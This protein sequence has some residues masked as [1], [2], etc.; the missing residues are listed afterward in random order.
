MKHKLKLKL[1]SDN[2]PYPASEK[3]FDN[4]TGT[5]FSVISSQL[6][7]K[8]MTIPSNVIILFKSNN[9]EFELYKLRKPQNLPHAER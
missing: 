3:W 1:K 8:C 5:F 7:G 6:G 9:R 2:Q 4:V